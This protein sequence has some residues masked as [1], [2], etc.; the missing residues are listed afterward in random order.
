MSENGKGKQEELAEFTSLD[1][2]EGESSTV[3]TK[4]VTFLRENLEGDKLAEAESILGISKDMT[5]EELFAKLAELLQGKGKED[6]EEEEEGDTKDMQ[7]RKKFMEECMKEGKDLATCNEEWKKKYPDAPE[8]S[9]EE[10]AKEK[11]EEEDY[12]EPAKKKMKE[13]ET[14]V[15]ELLNS[16]KTLESE[17]VK[18][19]IDSEVNK[20]VAEKH[21]SPIQR[22][23]VIKLSSQ[24]SP[25]LR[26]EFLGFFEKTQKFNV[27][28]DVGRMQSTKAGAAEEMTPERRVELVKK[29]GLEGLIADKA[30][31]TREAWW[32][33]KGGNN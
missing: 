27:S 9:A 29:F 32:N 15:N 4:L 31:K 2:E 17:K 28:E 12:P 19:E 6:E 1:L 18:A 3:L 24:M 7:D 16:V 20:L 23:G 10:L 14:R 21:L 33:P 8:K 13:L 30:D 25:E 26:T 11:E 5:N 22:D